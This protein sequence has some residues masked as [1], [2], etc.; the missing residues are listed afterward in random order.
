M[1][2]GANLCAQRPTPMIPVPDSTQTDSTELVRILRSDYILLSQEEGK[3]RQFLRGDVVFY[4]D[5]S[6]LYCD[7][8]YFE[9]NTVTAMGEVVILRNDTTR[10]FG[11]SLVYQGD[12]SVAEIFGD[13]LMESGS[14]RLTTRRLSYDMDRETVRYY[15]TSLLEDE[16]AEIYSQRGVYYR[17]ARLFEVA[18]SVYVYSD[19]LDVR[20]DTLRYLTGL[21]Q[22]LFEAPT[23]IKMEAGDMYCEDGYYDYGTGY[24]SFER[25]ARFTGQDMDARA[26]TI[27]YYSRLDSINLIGNAYYVS[28]DMTADGDFIAYN[29][30]SGDG[31]VLGDGYMKSNDQTMQGDEL[32]F[33]TETEEFQSTQRSHYEDV[34]MSLDADRMAFAQKDTD[35][36][37]AYGNVVYKDTIND[38]AIDTDTLMFRQADGYVRAFGGRPILKL[39]TDI[40]DTLYICAD[41]LISYEREDSVKELH[42]FYDV[43]IFSD[44]MQGVCDSLSYNDGDSTLRFWRQPMLWMD[45][46][47]LSSDTMSLKLADGKADL[48]EMRENG[49]IISLEAKP[50]Y[51][52]IRGKYI[53]GYFAE[54]KLDDVQVDGNAES[55]YYVRNDEKEFIGLNRSISSKIR[56]DF[57]NNEVKKIHW[58][59]QPELKYYPMSKYAHETERL[60]GF[61]WKYDLRP[62]QILDLRL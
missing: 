5:S 47:Q 39:E 38:L 30:Q 15:G 12:S 48:L 33:N 3:S 53:D 9:D 51:Q 28:S 29:R 31:K 41:T 35:W 54:N 6:Y 16:R 7:S 23:D 52:Q 8:A 19:S 24:A 44:D 55:I 34:T 18:D 22:V 57:D 50:Y 10:L 46:T 11:D 62:A 25:N 43:R 59:K 17:Q 14:Q 42:A 1:A 13:V 36:G 4:H 32:I 60:E 20:T 61:V 58:L 26:D 49:L 2:A 37:Y 56:I 45:S 27:E 40:Q 21:K